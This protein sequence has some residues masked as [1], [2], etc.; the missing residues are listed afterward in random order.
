MIGSMLVLNIASAGNLPDPVHTYGVTDSRVTQAN[1][2]T[3]ICKVGYT[4]TIRPPV[5]YTSALKTAQ[6]ASYYKGNCPNLGDCEED[7]LIS[8]ELGGSPTAEA[9][10]WP[11]PNAHSKDVCENRLHAKVCK[12]KLTLAEAQLGIAKN[13]VTYCAAN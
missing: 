11:Q 13:W 6:L 5:K 4:K 1:I 3:T 12:G 10:L 7:H 8:L 9:N 2:A